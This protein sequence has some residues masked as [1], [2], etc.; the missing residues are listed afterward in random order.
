MGH[1]ERFVAIAV[2]AAAALSASSASAFCRTTTC[3]AKNPTANCERDANA[4]STTGTPLFWPSP[5]LGFYVQKDGSA[6]RHVSYQTFDRI[7]QTAFNQWTASPCSGGHPRIEL[8]DLGPSDTTGPEYSDTEPN[9]NVWMFR[10]DDWPYVGATATLALTTVSF[11]LKS[12]KI[13]DADVEVNSY[14]NVITTS[15]AAPQA[16]LQS[17]VTHEAGHFLGMA[18]SAL[19]DATMFASYSPGDLS[20]RTLT[21]DDHQGICAAYPAGAISCTGPTAQEPAS[22][23]TTTRSGC[24]MPPTRPSGS[25]P[26]ALGLGLAALVHGL[27]R[28]GRRTA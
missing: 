10:D 8:W 2:A 1:A 26:F 14:L 20:F 5:C 9:T 6:K 17:I 23:T 19:A 12:G 16:D 7:V 21:D 25:S 4:C 28:R 24:S 15:D 13:L 11:G 27:R 22:S 18:H 3:D